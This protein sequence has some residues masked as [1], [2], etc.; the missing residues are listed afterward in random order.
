MNVV[1]LPISY[2][3]TVRDTMLFFKRYLEKSQLAAKQFES[4]QIPCYIK[5]REIPGPQRIDHHRDLLLECSS[6]RYMPYTEDWIVIEY[7]ADHDSDYLVSLLLDCRN[8][9]PPF[10]HSLKKTTVSVI[11]DC[12]ASTIVFCPV[13]SLHSESKKK[14][15]LF[16]DFVFV[17][18]VYSLNFPHYI[19]VYMPDD[20]RNRSSYRLA[21]L[22]VLIL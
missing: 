4:T 22:A 16:S 1:V 19:Y 6:L 13:L 11:S 7:F 9:F 14:K 10:A 12:N 17:F 21:V 3:F 18:F 20:S 15:K 2:Q 5:M 8:T